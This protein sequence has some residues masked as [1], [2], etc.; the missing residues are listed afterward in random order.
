MKKTSAQVPAPAAAARRPRGRPREFDRD[1]ALDR[2][3][4]VFWSKG[5]E[6]ATLS[7]LTKAMGI[8]PPSLYATFGDKEGLFIEAVRRYY[9]NVH[10]QCSGCP[11]AGAREHVEGF[12]TELAKMFTDAGHPRGCLAVMA[13][14]TA[15]ESSPR[16]QA[17]LAEKRAASKA[18]MRAR[19]QKGID[20]GELPADTDATALTNLYSAVIAGMSLQAREGATR[21][22][23]LAMV[24]AAMRAW[25]EKPAT[26][27]R[28]PAARRAS[29]SA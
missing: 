12:L 10:E 26:S 19:I 4:D 25:P 22:A 21:K 8:N 16:M 29:Y 1:Q 14:T 20:N 17:F 28:Q 15:L 5:F 2:A 6:A 9:I 7:D 3:L 18:T 11:D 13:M 27:S 23:L 24:D